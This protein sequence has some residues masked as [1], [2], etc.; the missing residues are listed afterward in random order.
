MVF[1]T[2]LNGVTTSQ[3]SEEWKSILLMLGTI[4]LSFAHIHFDPAAKSLVATIIV[5]TGQ[6]H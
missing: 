5:Q 6:Y 1:V 3:T 2:S 4:T